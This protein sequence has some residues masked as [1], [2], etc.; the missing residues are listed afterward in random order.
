MNR[1]AFPA[2]AIALATTVGAWAGDSSAQS[3]PAI[4]AGR[5]RSHPATTAA[6]AQ[7]QPA[8]TP[9]QA[10]THMA[11][12]PAGLAI[13]M[14]FQ[15]AYSLDYDEAL[16]HARRAVTLAPD[17]SAA[18]RARAA[19]VWLLILF[20]RGA[21][22]VD[23][24]MGSISR[25][26]LTLPKPPAELD[27]EF[28]QAIGKAIEL[29]EARLKRAP[30]DIEAR[31]DAG[32]AYGVQASY[33]ASVEGSVGA[34]FRHA[35]RAFDA[36]E[37]VL[38]R[39]PGRVSAGLVV[40]TYRYIV[41]SQALPTRLL[42]Y[43]VG[44]GG[45]KERGISMIE[46]ALK[47][48]ATYVDAQTALMLI[49]SREGRHAEVMGIAHDLATRYPRNRLFVL[50]E[51]A[52]AIRA[53]RAQ[54]AHAILTRGFEIL[55]R[56]ARPRLPGEK[57]VW[58]YKRG[59]ARLNLNRPADALVDLTEALS[60]QPQ[61]WIRGRIHVELGKLADLRGARAEAIAS[62]RSARATCEAN[63]DRACVNEAGRWLRR[64][65]SFTREG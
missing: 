32:S 6:Q 9:P 10:E 4:E 38:E 63:N 50:E 16:A 57:A 41:S 26:Q 11:A 21:A 58:L 56:D 28:R 43:V 19:V 37:H 51:G 35:K 31:F 59:L 34:A 27:A 40:G 54:E 1:L 39:D 47:D 5:A 20:Q 62:Y 55:E 45:G 2:A 3:D 14:A 52:A 17:N 13:H 44:F 48:P 29:A 15:A 8:T 12:S 53:G 25:S 61:G 30:N 22:S 23:Y 33:M 64:P 42:A 36:Q 7:S 49:Y 60:S 18:H 65:F 46:A 24:Y